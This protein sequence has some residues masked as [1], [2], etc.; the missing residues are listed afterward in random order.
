MSAN[1]ASQKT[2][3]QNRATTTSDLLLSMIRQKTSRAITKDNRSTYILNTTS[4]P[5]A[6]AVVLVIGSSVALTGGPRLLGLGHAVLVA[7]NGPG[8]AKGCH[9]GGFRVLP[10]LISFECT[11]AHSLDG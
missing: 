7:W 6:A 2:S 3:I 5:L 1:R 10:G 4:L 8:L 9:E 11:L